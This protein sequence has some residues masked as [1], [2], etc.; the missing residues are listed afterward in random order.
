MILFKDKKVAFALPPRTGSTTAKEFLFK[1]KNCVQLPNRHE[2]P[3]IFIKK[4]PTLADYKIYSFLRNPLERFVSGVHFV[5][6]DTNLDMSCDEFID[7]KFAKLSSFIVFKKQA[8]WFEGVN[9]EALNFDNYETELRRVTDGLGL[10]AH[11]IEW[12]N[13]SEGDPLEITD[14]VRNFVREYYAADYALAKERL[15]KE[16]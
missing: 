11:S 6:K 15:G 12:L 10:D 14:K 3:K 5:N 4:Y 7:N 13:K 1:S 16:Y 2:P 9:V 8:E